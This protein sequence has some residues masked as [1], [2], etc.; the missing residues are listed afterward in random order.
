ML[1]IILYFAPDVLDEQSHTMREI[2]DRHF[3]GADAYWVVPYYMGFLEELPHAWEP[4]KA[5]K[6]ALSNTTNANE[7]KRLYAQHTQ[8][9][10]DCRKKLAHFLTEGVLT[11]E[12]CLEHTND[13]L[14]CVR[15]CNVTIRWLMLHRRARMRKLPV[16][17][18][19]QER[20]E[21]EMLCPNMDL[22]LH[23]SAHHGALPL[24]AGASRGRDAAARADGHGP[25]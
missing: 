16:A 7:I 2:V 22:A 1:Y 24:P 21:A 15:M 3:A 13:L 11:E 25:V 23:A 6:A 20:R 19:E 5:A 8:N 17:D 12:L 4:Y 9:L 10:S 18:P 14:H